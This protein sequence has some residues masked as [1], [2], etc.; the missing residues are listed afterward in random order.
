VTYPGGHQVVVELLPGIPGLHVDPG[1]VVYPPLADE[2]A[3]ILRDLGAE[4]RFAVP[5]A[6]RQV[7][8]LRGAELWIPVLQV[9]GT[10][11]LGAVGSLV[12]EAI[13]RL[14]GRLQKGK[15]AHEHVGDLDV[16]VLIGRGPDGGK[17]T[18]AEL[19]GDASKVVESLQKLTE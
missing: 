7:A 12:A 16:H 2:F 18:W 3:E 10:V 6:E 1:S 4:T 8:E 17:V 5:D 11:S 19:H 15:N 14:A 9:T 13:I